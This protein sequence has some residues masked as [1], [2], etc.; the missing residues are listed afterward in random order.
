M[1]SSKQELDKLKI[2]FTKDNKIPIDVFEEEYWD[3]YISLYENTH[4]S[5][6]KWLSLL[7]GIE[8]EYPSVQ[9]FLDAFYKRREVMLQNLWS[10]TNK[11]GKNL[12]ELFNSGEKKISS[13]DNIIS[14]FYNNEQEWLKN[15]QKK[16]VYNPEH[17]GEWFLSIDLRK[18]NFQAMLWYNPEFFIGKSLKSGQSIDDL[19]YEWISKF[20]VKGEET[21]N[22]YI[23][24]SKYF[25]EVVFG[26]LNPDRA[27]RIEKWMIAHV[28]EKV[29]VILDTSKVQ[30]KFMQHG[31]DE[32]VIKVEDYE[33]ILNLLPILK[34]QVTDVPEVGPVDVKVELYQLEDLCLESNNGHKVEAYRKN[35]HDGKFV[36][37]KVHKH[38]YA[39]VYEICYG[40]Q[41]DEQERD[42]IFYSENE[43]AKFMHRIKK[44]IH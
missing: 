44:V 29:K 9:S 4:Q 12:M 28:S 35:H 17:V 38:Y 14:S 7:E 24:E 18:A 13:R 27:I 36:L 10:K 23:R 5:R 40:I 6:T 26:N 15:I 25:R 33:K 8:K 41:P 16:D 11:D 20:E 3:F 2:R 31:S 43:P 39:Q 22:S 21:L 32:I 30:Y 19:Y 34:Q 37:K 1:N 42:L